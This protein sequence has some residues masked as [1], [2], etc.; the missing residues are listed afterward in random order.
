MLELTRFFARL[1]ATTFY[2]VQ[3]CG[4]AKLVRLVV[5]SLNLAEFSLH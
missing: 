5:L 4:K 2:L 3:V 1:R